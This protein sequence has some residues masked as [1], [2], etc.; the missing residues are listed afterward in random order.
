[1]V[2]FYQGLFMAFYPATPHTFA[3]LMH[4][5]NIAKQGAE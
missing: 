2:I 5:M 1:M 4:H 3:M